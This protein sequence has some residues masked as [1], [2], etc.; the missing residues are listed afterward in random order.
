MQ[1]H[2]VVFEPRSEGVFFTA[3]HEPVVTAVGLK[4]AQGLLLAG[5][6]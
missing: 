2:I 3:D 6:S 4:A 5:K 1:A